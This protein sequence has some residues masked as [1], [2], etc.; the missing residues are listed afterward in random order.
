M[1]E[2]KQFRMRVE[3]GCL[4]GLGVQHRLWKLYP[5]SIFG[6]WLRSLC[7]SSWPSTRTQTYLLYTH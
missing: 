6:H 7:V 5:G 3:R 2:K 4:E 1:W